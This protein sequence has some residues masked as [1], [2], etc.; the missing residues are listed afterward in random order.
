MAVADWVDGRWPPHKD[1]PWEL[2]EFLIVKETGWTLDYI[3]SLDARDFEKIT[4]MSNVYRVKMENKRIKQMR[5][6]FGV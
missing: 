1:L 3:R 5:A 6:Q 4:L 2:R